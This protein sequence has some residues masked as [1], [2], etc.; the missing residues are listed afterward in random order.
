M[1]NPGEADLMNHQT[2]QIISFIFYI[3]QSFTLVS[4]TVMLIFSFAIFSIYK[5][6]LLFILHLSDFNK[7][8]DYEVFYI[9]L[10]IACLFSILSILIMI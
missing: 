7:K 10:V 3:F 5:F 4:F 9:L 2:N 8:G 6:Q 1:G